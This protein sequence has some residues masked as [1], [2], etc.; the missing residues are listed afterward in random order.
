MA[1]VP[2]LIILKLPA[3]AKDIHG[4]Y[5]NGSNGK[6]SKSSNPRSNPRSNLGS[7]QNTQDF[8]AIDKI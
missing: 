2:Y 4:L 5:G 3:F 7:N 6:G 1:L 8:L